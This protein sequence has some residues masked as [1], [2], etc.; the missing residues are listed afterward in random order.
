MRPDLFPAH[1]RQLARFYR[2]SEHEFVDPVLRA[3]Q[4]ALAVW[5]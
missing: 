4:P 1:K 2:H 3:E 5:I